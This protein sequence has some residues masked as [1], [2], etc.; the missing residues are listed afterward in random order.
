MFASCRDGWLYGNGPDLYATHDGGAH[1]RAISLGGPIRSMAVGAGTAYAMVY[2]SSG[3][4]LWR[5]PAATSA[6]TRAATMTGSALGGVREGGLVRQQHPAVGHRQRGALAPEP[7][8][9]PSTRRDADHLPSGR[10]HR[11]V[12]AS[13]PCLSSAWCMSAVVT[14]PTIRP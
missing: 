3:N 4:Q 8:E 10:P 9:Q 5:S 12:P 14:M 7:A 1:W 6:W 11:G 2:R 13:T